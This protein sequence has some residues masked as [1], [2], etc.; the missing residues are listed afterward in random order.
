MGVQ[1]AGNIL[2]QSNG[3][4]LPIS[5][6]GTGQTTATGA[7]NALLPVQTGNSGKVLTTDGTN[8][9]WSS[10]AGGTPGGADTQ[11]QY[12]DAGTF[13]GSSAFVINKSTGALTATNTFKSLGL[14]V[15]GNAATYRSLKL[16]T[17]GSDR[18]LVQANNTAESGS[19]VGSNFEL[20]SVADNGLT[21][22]I[23]MSVS[24]STQVVNFLNS[25]TVGGSSLQSV[26]LPSQTGNNGKFLTTDGSSASW[27]TVS[28]SPG[29]STTQIQFNSSGSFAGSSKFTWT[30]GSSTLG[31]GATGSDAVISALGNPGTGV[32]G[33]S[34]SIN[35][36]AGGVTG[37]GG[38]ITLQ[39]GTGQSS[40]T[41]GAINIFGGGAGG[42]STIGGS[43]TIRAGGSSSSSTAGSVTVQGG[44]G[45]TVF[46]GTATNKFSA[47]GGVG[48]YGIGANGAGAS[49]VAFP[50]SYTNGGGGSGGTQTTP[51]GNPPGGLYGGGGGGQ[52]N[53]GG[54][55]Q[56][57]G[58]S[59]AVRII[60]GDGRSFPSNAA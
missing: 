36:S 22:N 14:L 55:F 44:A 48:I 25:P 3:G 16:Q 42:T 21:Q 32:A 15:S 54:P 49:P 23:V 5:Q 11:I 30:D 34:I 53:S 57:D 10:S 43:V 18:W 31:L 59:G 46:G 37:N 47:G 35:A 26:V 28:A 20:V 9:S 58:G 7:I 1:F 50:T 2:V 24:R 6:G 8:V 56:G 45:S 12:N 33:T 39:A 41:G 4:P 17:A 27:A 40:A 52:T 38:S 51:Q 19:N 13:N 60:W 29:G